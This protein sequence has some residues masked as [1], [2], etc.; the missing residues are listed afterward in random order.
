MSAVITKI[1]ANKSQVYS[2]SRTASAP[3]RELFQLNKD[4][5]ILPQ[6][7]THPRFTP[8]LV[9][10]CKRDFSW[11][12]VVGWSTTWIRTSGRTHLHSPWLNAWL[13]AE[14]HQSYQHGEPQPADQDVEHPR[15][16]AQTECARLV[17]CPMDERGSW[18]HQWRWTWSLINLSKAAK[19]QFIREAEHSPPGT[20]TRAG[21]ERLKLNCLN[22]QP[23][24][25]SACK[26][27]HSKQVKTPEIKK[28]L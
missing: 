23:L 28:L 19:V 1:G 26:C 13:V 18:R 10:T 9:Q 20:S 5:A 22:S 16:V 6:H 2:F 11:Q 7:P 4:V 17:L 25:A 8:S 12:F 15:H 21:S 24:T 3:Q 14:L 27:M